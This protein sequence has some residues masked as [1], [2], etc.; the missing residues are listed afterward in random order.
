ME[1]YKKIKKNFEGIYK[2]C[3]NKFWYSCGSYL[4]DG[5]N[6]KYDQRM[7]KKQILLYNLAKKNKS[8]LE[9]GVYMGHSMLLMLTSNPKLRILGLDA[10]KRFA[11][12]SIK[13]LKEKFPKSKINFTLGDSIKSLKKLNKSF[14]LYHIDGDHR[15]KKIYKEII[16][17]IRLTKK[18]I[19]K[20]LFD[21]VDMMLNVEASLFKC[22]RV[23]KF[24]KPDSRYRN[25]YVE[26][27]LDEKSIKKFKNN[28]Y[29]F[30][31]IDFPKSY[32]LPF[33]KNILRTIVKYTLG[34]KISHNLG[35]LINKYFTNKYLKILAVK[36]KNIKN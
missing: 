1:I 33:I 22:F 21:D 36:L 32:L 26:L 23:I 10:D 28:Y 18:D 2:A 4:I 17:C 30:L 31:F 19:I 12:K 20:I 29:I 14:D 27:K 24:I 15:P 5:E 3:G 16:E 9:V 13:Y 34:K 25:L 7:L 35:K 6:Y 8:I 11:P